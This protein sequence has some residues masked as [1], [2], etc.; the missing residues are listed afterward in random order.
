MSVRA[1]ATKLRYAIHH[2]RKAFDE[3]ELHWRDGVRASFEETRLR[4]LEQQTDAVI[5]GMIELD[6]LFARVRRELRDDLR[7]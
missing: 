5:R 3:T 6:N 7:E 1:G 2:L 4:P